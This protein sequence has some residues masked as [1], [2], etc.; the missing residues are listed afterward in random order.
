MKITEVE[1][2]VVRHELGPEAQFCYSQA[3]YNDRTL[4]LLRLRTDDG[5]EGWGEAFGPA[6][7]HKATIDS[8]Y[9]PYLLGRDPFDSDAVWTHLYNK[10]RDHGQKGLAIEALS[11]VDIAMW[12]LKGKRTGLPAYK[13]MGGS[14][15]AGILPYATGMY[16]RKEGFDVESITSEARSYVASGFKGIKIKI[17]FGYEYDV[18]TV[19]A[20]REE[21]GPDIMLMVDANH[22][23]NAVT[24]IKIGRAIQDYDLA[25]FEEPVPPEDIEGYKEV[26]RALEIPVAGGE[27]EFT[28]YGFYRLL[29]ERA[30]DIV[31]P[32]CGVTGG[33]SEFLKIATLASVHNIQCYPHV[34]GSAIAV[35]TGIH[36]CF[37]LPDFPPSLYPGPAL[38]ELDRTPN[39]FRDKLSKAEIVQD[40][41][42]M[43][44]PPTTPGLGVEVDMDLIDNHR[45]A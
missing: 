9:T 32:D 11:A 34:W 40:C 42:G 7:P 41:S 3:W 36:C 29:H 10:L 20:V 30:V 44:L 4:L 18:A 5:L 39:V 21:V 43:I 33:I 31:Q 27:A 24:A 45:I 14:H 12:D 37:A 6:L 13:L 16:R 28:R 26:R 23:Y 25:W 17:G 8:L 22:A 15:R 38:L 19:R 1:T 35:R 2:F